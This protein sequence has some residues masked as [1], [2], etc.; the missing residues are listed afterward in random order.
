MNFKTYICAIVFGA[1]Q[2]DS[3]HISKLILIDV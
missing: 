3:Y 1:L 2:S